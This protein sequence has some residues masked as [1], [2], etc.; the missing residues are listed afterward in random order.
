MAAAQTSTRAKP[1]PTPAPSAE[2]YFDLSLNDVNKFRASEIVKTA[3]NLIDRKQYDAAIKELDGALAIYPK[4][5]EAYQQRGIA[6]E[7][8]GETAKALADLTKAI[9]FGPKDNYNYF[10]RGSLYHYSVKN[11]E[12]AIKDLTEAIR[13]NPSSGP[14]FFTR[15]QALTAVKRYDAAIADYTS[16][17]KFDATNEYAFYF[18]G[19]AY[20]ATGRTNLATADYRKALELAP[21]NDSFKRAIAALEKTAVTP[22]T[23]AT[24]S[25]DELFAETLDDYGEMMDKQFE[26]KDAEYNAA[27]KQALAQKAA[28]AAGTV[29]GPLDTSKVCRILGELKTINASMF[30]YYDLLNGMYYD[31]DVKNYPGLKQIFQDYEESQELIDADEK[32]EP[33]LWNCGADSSG[34]AKLTP[35]QSLIKSAGAEV[36][37]DK[38]MA[39]FDKTFAKLIKGLAAKD[40]NASKITR[41]VNCNYYDE[42][43][44]Q[45]QNISNQ[46]KKMDA[47]NQRPYVKGHTEYDKRL[48]DFNL[49][50]RPENCTL[51]V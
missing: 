36:D 38:L 9:E 24:K 5:A 1:T 48:K 43:K 4:S 27:K 3:G 47:D 21:A 22:K 49:V 29:K 30:D 51:F 41:S 7:K 34:T 42:S 37:V 16:A 40:A 26:P 15:A 31:G 44:K 14:N 12:L 33:A 35:L 28:I 13:L 10:L 20:A 39:E 45:L 8:K 50:K 46:L 11:D 19:N 32:N 23:P 2:D 17:L 6:H 18:R 25:A